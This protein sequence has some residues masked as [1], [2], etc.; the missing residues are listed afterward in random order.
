M[1]K[2]IANAGATT[3]T[4]QN[5]GALPGNGGC[6]IQ[7]DVTSST[8]RSYTNTIASGAVQTTVGN[9]SVAATAVLQV[10]ALPTIAKAFS[11]VAIPLGASS[12][13]TLTLGN[14]NAVALLLAADFVDA[15]PASL[16]LG[17]PATVGGS[18]ASVN[19]VVISGGSSITYK[20]GASIPAGGC[21]ITVPV[22]SA[23]PGGYDNVIAAGALVTTIGS[24]PSGT[25]AHL[26]ILQADLQITKTDGTPTAVPG[27]T[28]TYT[29]VVTNAGPSAVTGATVADNFPAAITASPWT[30][31]YSA[32]SSGPLA[33]SGN[34]SA[35]VNLLAGGTATFTVVATLSPSVTG[36]LTNTA[37]VTAPANVNDPT[38]GNNSAT[39]T[40]TLTPQ[41]DL[42]ITKTDGVATVA[43]GTTTTYTIVA[44]NNGPSAV[45]GATV[46]DTFP[47][48][49]TS[50][51]W[52][53]AY[54]A[55]S[56]GPA[57]GSGNIS[58]LVN[59]LPSGTATF[60][61][62][63]TIASSATGSLVN[64]ATVTVPGG[65]TDTNPG[66]NSATDTDTLAPSA[67]LAVV[68]TGPATALPGGPNVTFSMLVTNNGPSD[69]P[70]V[71][72]ADPTPANLTFVSASGPCAGGFPCA[73]G[74]LARGAS[75]TVTTTY[76][77][78]SGYPKPAPIVNV[79]TV[80]S[81]TGIPDPIPSNDSSSAT[82]SVPDGFADLA[83]TKTVSNPAPAV[84]SNV[85]F[86]ITLRNNGPSDASAIRVT[87]VLPSGLTFVSSAPSQGTYTAATGLWAAGSL[88]NGASATLGI[89]ATVTQAG[90]IVNTATATG[91][92][93]IDPNPSNNSGSAVVNG[94]PSVAD[95]QV[96]K[97]V[98]NAAPTVGANVTFTLTVT[99][100]G[101]SAATGVVVTDLLPSGLTFVSATPSQGLY[102]SAT[103]VWTIGGIPNGGVVT[104]AL[105]ATVTANGTYVNT[106]KKTAENE[107]DPNLSNDSAVAGLVAGG[108]GA[109]FADLGIAKSDSPDPVR[110]GQ[111]LTYTLVV[112]NRGPNDATGVTVTDPLPASVT[113]V[114]AAP[115]QGGCSGTTTITCALGGLAR[116]SSATITIVVSVSAAAVPSITNTAS[117]TANETD[118]NPGDNS[119]TAPTTVLPVADV[120]LL[121]IVS[122]P[123]P[124][125]SQSFTFTITAT[126]NGPSTANGVV[127]TDVLP[128]NIGFVSFVASQGGYV[129]GTGVW[130]VGTLL[131]GAS[132][133]LTL[134]VT[135]LAPGAFTNTA[136]KTGQTEIDPNPANDSASAS[137]GVGVV[138][139][140]TIVKTHAPASFARGSTGTFSLTVSNGGTGPTNG[141]VTVSDTLPA[142]LTPT[143]ASGAGWACTVTA[144]SV[145]CS[146]ADVLG[147]GAAWPAIS[148]TVNVLQS[149]AAS[150][151]NT[152]SVG[153]GGDVTPGNNGATDVVPVVSSA[154]LAIVKTGPPNAIPGNNVVYTLLVTNNGPSDAASVVVSDPTPPS[155]TF[156][157]NTGSCATPFPCAL[158]AVPVG[159]TR[160][161][162]TTFAIPAGYTT[163][164]PIVN[165]ASVSSA[166]PDPNPANDSSR[167]TASVA[168][169]LSVVKTIEGAP[170]VVGQTFT[171]RIVVTNHGP[172]TATG[173]VLTDSL[174]ASVTLS[175][176]TT[177]QGSC[178]GTTT[179]TCAL[180]TLLNGA[181]ATVLIHVLPASATA[182]VA[183]TATVA[184]NE[185][186]PD[187]TNNTST[188]DGSLLSS[189]PT[190]SEW[191]LMALFFALALAGAC[192]LRR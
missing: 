181:S 173:I 46:A 192:T 40:D 143:A 90:T 23:V 184:A 133:T 44:R 74:G 97:T 4:Y 18:C 156:V 161:I 27:T 115:S 31:V 172:S 30:A 128:A 61:V 158:G 20:S 37:T 144:P 122:N 89:T 159:A 162:T 177:T 126:N 155:L 166:T 35:A 73:L 68:K 134:T 95:I 50:A 72:L 57:S 64:T 138:A 167:A 104:L 132:A 7:V 49:I 142:G 123:A 108:G 39:D 153:G 81:S 102:V 94:P 183:N 186:D 55:G 114:S 116:G 41:A 147:A 112:T 80:A 140:L 154:D 8:V 70:G 182:S 131:N 56:S 121:K 84:G 67:D 189:V 151:T 113:L 119:A 71:T 171:Y 175:S 176:L 38:P 26:D 3:V 13:L 45:T 28:T 79:A 96:Q 85:T 124:L 15:L 75:T 42:A 6:T 136:T 118:P 93:E 62:V 66:N 9:N 157:S 109:T 185:F 146:R 77:V 150:V 69:V 180:G 98:N 100:A 21:T 187:G 105:V 120:A 129:S 53:A 178:S 58:A 5:G 165:T 163:P 36:S 141:P 48:A 149:A 170:I 91:S 60:T 29:I 139:D 11:P 106:A 1:A 179:V 99:N 54:S 152:A 51:T 168:A 24:N 59:L 83:V 111:N 137:V 25:S 191:A 43:P 130:T 164:S 19:V 2:V 52:T 47:A 63:A 10:L 190:L 101:P 107:F 34:I 12:V 92:N 87:D 135:A 169:D 86:T 103:G 188:A 76:A 127:V 125:V 148:V 117:V 160:T 22:T 33:G 16:V 78:P 32:G 88:V 14:T 17:T 110:A 145:S 174:P 82:V 65:V